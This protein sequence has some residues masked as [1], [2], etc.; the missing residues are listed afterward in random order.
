LDLPR[1]Y[2]ETP[3]ALWQETIQIYRNLKMFQYVGKIDSEKLDRFKKA[4]F[5]VRLEIFMAVRMMFS[6]VSLRH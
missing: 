2:Q 4:I 5:C 6:S 3:Q 1:L